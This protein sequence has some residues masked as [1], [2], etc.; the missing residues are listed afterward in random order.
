M[1][2]QL[3]IPLL[4]ILF[5]EIFFAPDVWAEEA[6]NPI[7]AA[8]VLDPRESEVGE[9]LIG[10]HFK[11]EPGWHLYWRYAGDVGLPT[12]VRFNLPEGA[13]V[14]ELQWPTPV[15]FSQSGGLVGIGYEGE[16][17][18]FARLR[19]PSSLSGEAISLQARWV[20]CSSKVCVPNREEFTF[21][22]ADL[23]SRN[24]LQ[25][26][27]LEPWFKRVPVQFSNTHGQATV[28]SSKDKSNP[29][30]SKHEIVFDWKSQAEVLEWFPYLP[31]N[32]KLQ[33]LKV[34]TL[35]QKSVVTFDLERLDNEGIEKLAAEVIVDSAGSKQGYEQL[36]N[37]N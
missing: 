25:V 27:D 13:S 30:L 26:M 36:I 1:M 4:V 16:T 37:L 18:L 12:Q 28:S 20:A 19:V 15:R 2:P 29:K 7:K 31:R 35:G 3:F 33:N 23:L 6:V 8:V 17:V 24:G 11:I 21:K 5:S 14:G 34:E 32:L 22:A 9:F 10:V